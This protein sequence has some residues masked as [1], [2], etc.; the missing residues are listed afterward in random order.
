MKPTPPP[1]TPRRALLVGRQEAGEMP[2]LSDTVH[3]KHHCN[4]YFH[5]MWGREGWAVSSLRWKR[6]SCSTTW[7]SLTC[8]SSDRRHFSS[9]LLSSASVL[10]FEKNWKSSNNSV[11]P[12]GSAATSRWPVVQQTNRVTLSTQHELS[13]Q[14]LYSG[15]K[16]KSR[17]KLK[18]KKDPSI[19]SFQLF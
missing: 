2:R 10:F 12:L 3:F 4:M 19:A 18:K 17:L 1:Q 9:Q 5:Q 6:S 15:R 8:S 14:Y 16:K 13:L 7:V 11:R